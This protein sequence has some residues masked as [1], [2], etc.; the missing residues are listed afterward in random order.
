MPN[1]R[2]KTESRT[3][4][5]WRMHAC[6]AALCTGVQIY[7]AGCGAAISLALSGVWAAALTSPPM[8]L[9]ITHSC[10]TARRREGPP[11]VFF[12]VLLALTLFFCAVYAVCASAAFAA[13]T[14]VSQAQT[15]W[16]ASLCTLF[17]ALCATGSSEGISRLSFSLRTALPASIITLILFALPDHPPSGLFPILGTGGVPLVLAALCMLCGAAPALLLL[18]PPPGLEDCRAQEEPPPARFF[19]MR[20]LAG[21]IIGVLLLFLAGVCTTYESLLENKGWGVRLCLLSQYQPH[22]GVLQMALTLLQLCAMI[23]LAANML[24]GAHRALAL[25]L[26]SRKTGKG[27]LTALTTALLLCVLCAAALGDTWLLIGLPLLIV[28]SLILIIF[29]GRVVRL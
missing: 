20:M 11:S 28:P 2:R 22:R 5:A 29:A 9:L 24:G 26:R 7:L 13:Q 12:C 3:H 15:V 21:S 16:I 23:L 10:R 4:A 19:L 6:T 27:L 8:A 25:A 17:A 14:L 1:E 18:L